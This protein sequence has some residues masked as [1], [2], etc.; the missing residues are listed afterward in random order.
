[1]K[2]LL[3]LALLSPFSP[4]L[5]RTMKVRVTSYAPNCRICGTTGTTATGRSASG[6]GVAV[7]PRFIRL[8][9]RVRILSRGFSHSWLRADDT[10]GKVKGAHIDL[11]LPSHAAARRFGS[12]R[13]L[14]EVLPPLKR[15]KR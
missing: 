13:L 14:I 10:G 7:D 15:R 8:H 4:A 2:C 1:M 9:S 11:R 5:A 3:T 6:P 12:R